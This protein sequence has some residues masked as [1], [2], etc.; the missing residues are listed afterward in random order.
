MKAG[1]HIV[2]LILQQI[3]TPDVKEVVVLGETK[4]GAW[5][6]G[7]KDKGNFIP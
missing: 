7:G 2:Y 1:D 3:K 4:R 6:R 5:I